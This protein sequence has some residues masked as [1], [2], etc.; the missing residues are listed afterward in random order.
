MK[1]ANLIRSK[2]TTVRVSEPETEFRC[3]CG[4]VFIVPTGKL[5]K[6]KVS[7]G[8]YLNPDGSVKDTE[9]R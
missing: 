7:C 1:G 3:S 4:R 2:L 6:N 5:N 8:E 9:E